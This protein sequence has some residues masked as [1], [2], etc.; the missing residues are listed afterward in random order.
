MRKEVLFAGLLVLA[1]CGTVTRGASEDVVIQ[2]APANA[3]VTTSLGATCTGSCVVSAPRNKAF[4]VTAEAP[5]H[6]PQ[7]VNVGLRQMEN[8]GATQAGSFMAG[9]L[10]G[11]GIDAAAGGTND[12]YPNPVVISLQPAG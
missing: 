11:M 6:L 10:V 2:V 8:A 12:H 3:K 1:G 9:G 5:G 4:T 7:T